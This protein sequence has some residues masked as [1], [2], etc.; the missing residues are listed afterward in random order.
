MPR[1]SVVISF[2]IGTNGRVDIQMDHPAA[3]NSEKEVSMHSHLEVIRKKFPF[4]SIP[5]TIE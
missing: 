5:I 2:K 3:A 1:F 4:Y